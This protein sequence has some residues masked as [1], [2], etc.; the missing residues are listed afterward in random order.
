VCAIVFAVSAYVIIDYLSKGHGAEQDVAELR[1]L[2]T[3]HAEGDP[4]TYANASERY[5]AL[6]E[7]NGD[8]VGWLRVRGMDIDYPVTQTPDD[9]EY[10]L[11]RNFEREYSRAGT[12]FASAIDDIT[13]PS[14]VTIIYGHKMKNGSMFGTLSK[15][16][17]PDFYDEHRY[18][19]FDTLSE[20]RS[21]LIFAVCKTS[22]NTGEA[23]EYR[24]YDYADFA[25]E[26]DFDGFIDEA[27]RRQTFDA[28]VPVSYGDEIILLSTCEGE[29]DSGRLIVLGKRIPNEDA[30]KY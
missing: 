23:S 8:F 9:P 4:D 1:H 21:Y 22:V 24:Y 29:D 27:R 11:H 18:L 26:A 6:F 12:L 13:K 16:S 5:R 15:L 20:R 3:G 17:D 2:P 14:D 25:D 10:Y 7:R 28:G 30:P 19:R